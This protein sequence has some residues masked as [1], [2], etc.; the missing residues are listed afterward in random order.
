MIARR[1]LAESKAIRAGVIPQ[2]SFARLRIRMSASNERERD[3]AALVAQISDLE[4]IVIAC[5]SSR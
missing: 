5:R 1:A 4:A 2:V 3:R